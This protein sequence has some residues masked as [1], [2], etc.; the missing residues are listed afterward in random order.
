MGER[1]GAAFLHALQMADGSL[2]IGRF[3]HSYGLEAWHD[4]NPDAD[5]DMLLE[6]VRNTLTESVATLDAAGVAL[7]HAAASGGDLA[8]LERIDLALT[9]RKLSAPARRASALCGSRLAALAA[10]IDVR[11]EVACH[12]ARKIGDGAWDGN[13]ALVEGALGA[14]MGVSRRHTVLVSVR[15]HAA[16]LLSSA[17]RLGRLGTNRSQGLLYALT[18]DIERS[19]RAAMG[20]SLDELGSTLPELEIHAAR[21]EYRDARLFMT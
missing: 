14:G 5:P 7:A 10:E 16:A 4:A 13:L 3:A 11:G 21:H 15:G 8:R 1:G 6:L 20:V 19:A 2:P 12:M 17:V 18:P 9:A